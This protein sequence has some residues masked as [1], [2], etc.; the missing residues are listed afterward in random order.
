MNLHEYQSKQL[1]QKFDV[2]VPFGLCIEENTRSAIDT[3]LSHFSNFTQ[4]V[5]KA[6]VHAGGR[7]KGRFID[8]DLCGVQVVPQEGA[9]T[10]IQNMLGN[11]L[12]TPQTG[13]EGKH[14]RKVYLTEPIKVRSEFY[15]SLLID[16]AHHCTMLIVSPHG[17]QDVENIAE[18]HPESIFKY[19]ID[20]L[21]G[22]ATFQAR[23]ATYALQLTGDAFK[24]C[25]QLLQNLYRAF[26]HLDA[27]LIEINPLS[28][29]EEGTLCALDAKIQ[30]DDNA[31]VRHPELAALG[32]PHE[33]DSKEV[34]A[35]AVKLNYVA[36]K[37]NIACLV[38]GAGLAMATMDM[39]QHFGGQPANFL[40][41]GGSAKQEQM[42]AAFHII[43]KDPQV[44]GIF[45][46][47]FAGILRCDILAQGIVKAAHSTYLN[48]PLVIRMQGNQVEKAKQILKE[49]GLHLTFMD[50]FSQAAQTIVQLAK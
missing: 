36:L 49:S 38:N 34:E 50:D 39:I 5:L 17:G 14:V 12:V 26:I 8:K 9:K 43:S 46:N 15:V 37:G 23:Q 29:T 1:L 47:I 20:P 32:D 40:D 3:A 13:A 10:V 25:V 44:K 28:L 18:A 45:I 42:E 4:I 7:G 21:I 24:A 35:E 19:Q 31:L 30:I 33:K 16:R 11:I 2:P 27:T 48:S 41:V 6:Q 22:L